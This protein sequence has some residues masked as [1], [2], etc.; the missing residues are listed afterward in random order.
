M[1][2]NW[3]VK[4]KLAHRGLHNEKFPENSLPA[5]QNAIDHNFAIE[6]DVRVSKDGSLVIFHDHNLMRMCSVDLDIKNLTLNE[7]KSHKLRSS[8]YTIPTLQEVLELVDGKVPIM[9]ELKPVDKHERIEE[10][11]LAVIKSYQG[12]LAV[13]SFN[14][15]TML[16][17]KKHA[18]NITRGMLSSYFENTNL[19][20]I[21]KFLIKRLFLFNRIKPHFISY[22]LNNLPN[23]YVKNKKVPILAWTITS[24]DMEKE[25]LKVADNVIFQDYIPEN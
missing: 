20:F 23:K 5:F 15:L 8:N 16:W 13:K 19:P 6:L 7:I 14:P 3:F 9:I 22:D 4:Y 25:A 21:Y 17:F 18:P 12:D 24:I 1:T 10:K 2:N 11:V